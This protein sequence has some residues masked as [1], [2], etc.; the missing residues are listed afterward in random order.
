MSRGAMADRATKQRGNSTTL[1]TQQ[2]QERKNAHKSL[3]SARKPPMT[4][5]LMLNYAGGEI[6]FGQPDYAKNYAGILARSLLNK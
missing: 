2:T 1:T 6:S 4:P 5:L 3:G